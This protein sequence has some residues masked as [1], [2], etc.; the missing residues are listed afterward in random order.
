[1]SERGTVYLVHFAR[2]LAHAR[3]YIGWTENE[4]IRVEFHREGR[5]SRLLAAIQREE[6]P[7]LVVRRWKGSRA[8]ERYLKRQRNAPAFCPVCSP[9]PRQPT[10][11]R[12]ERERPPEPG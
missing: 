7:W 8:R 2:P 5:G 11:G 4:E 3:H 12:L 10:W 1:V 6:I 9:R